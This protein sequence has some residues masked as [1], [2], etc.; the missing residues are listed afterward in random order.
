MKRPVDVV[1]LPAP[2]GAAS[3]SW[4]VV[5]AGVCSALAALTAPAQEAP[6]TAGLAFRGVWLDDVE[7]DGARWARGE[8]CKLA[9]TSS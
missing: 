4:R 3:R 5:A 7:S 2:A 9:V 1:P 6:P 8:T